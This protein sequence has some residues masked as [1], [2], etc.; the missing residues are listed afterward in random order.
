M[1]IIVKHD[2]CISENKTLFPQSE[3]NTALG[4]VLDF[5]LIKA[6]AVIGL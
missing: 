3:W 5:K 2:Q 6:V 4:S 1:K